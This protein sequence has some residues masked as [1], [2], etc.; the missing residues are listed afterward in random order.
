MINEVRPGAKSKLV[1]TR[2]DSSARAL[3]WAVW[4]VLLLI[5]LLQLRIYDNIPITE[6]WQLVPAF[7][8][9][10]PNLTTWLW[11]QNNEHRVPLPK[12]LLLL[13]LKAGG[14]DFRIGMLANIAL[15]AATSALLIL[16]ARTVR[17][18]RSCFSDA[19]FPV[20]LMNLGNWENLFWAWQITFV[21]S[22]VPV[23]VILVLLVRSKGLLT[24]ISATF[25]GISLVILPLCGGTGLLFVPLLAIWAGFLGVRAIGSGKSSRG[26][27][28]IL[29]SSVT[30]SACIT[31]AYF[32]G[33]VRPSWTGPRPGLGQAVLVAAQ[34]MAF[35][36]GPV[37]TASW[38]LFVIIDWLLI[39][40]AAICIF[41]SIKRIRG[42]ECQRALGILVFFLTTFFYAAAFGYGRARVIADVYGAWPTRYVLL[43]VPQL[44][45]IYFIWQLYAPARLQKY[46]IVLL[47]IVLAVLP[48][49]MALG[50]RSSTWYVHGKQAVMDVMGRSRADVTRLY[51]AMPAIVHESVF[52][53]LLWLKIAPTWT[54]PSIWSPISH[55]LR[56]PLTVTWPDDGNGN[57]STGIEIFDLN[58]S[59]AWV[60]EGVARR[61]T[62]KSDQGRGEVTDADA[63]PHTSKTDKG[64]KLECRDRRVPS[65]STPS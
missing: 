16:T 61:R 45:V 6:D 53:T 29:V 63:E 5:A 11:E 48:L 57:E 3:T 39:G 37:V 55:F 62:G 65:R 26:T 23:C 19:F 17:G 14:G 40:A 28:M 1:S 32:V 44:C 36:F 10:Q 58:L 24:P 42:P 22:V 50:V 51:V 54:T 56:L 41:T 43:A 7:T 2:I 49:N 59:V 34:F 18:G 46:S 64:R 27:G 38:T 9:H 35:A 13:L 33:Y 12:V 60:R 15:L 47:G 4:L 30:L 52:R 21:L 31:V 20:A 8:G 25:A